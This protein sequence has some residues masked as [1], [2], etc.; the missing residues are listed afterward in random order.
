MRLLKSRTE[1]TSTFNSL[2]RNCE[3]V[4]F[5]VAWASCGFGSCD[6]LLRVHRKIRRGVVGTHFYQTDPR[7]IEKFVGRKSVKF[8]T[9]PSGVFHPKVYLFERPGSRWSC[10]IGSANFTL[11]AFG[12][13]S[14][15][16]VL[17][18]DVDGPRSAIASEV[19]HQIK[20]YWNWPTAKF[21][22]QIDL[23]RYRYWKDRFKRPIDKSQGKFGIKPAKK[24]LDEI[25]LLN[26]G[27]SELFS[28]I[29]HDPH[30]GLTKRIKVLASAR[31]LFEKYGS[32]AA[33]P[34]KDRQGIAGF[35][36]SDDIP[37]G[38]FGSM[39]GAGT[40]KKLVNENPKAFSTALDKIPLVGPVRRSDYE[41]F[42][43]H[44]MAAFPRIKRRRIRHGLATA[45]RL[46]AMKRPDYFVCFD[47]ANKVGLSKAFG[48]TI[49]HHDYNA[50]WDS[51]IERIC[52]SKWWN[53]PR[54]KAKSEQQVW[55]GRTAFLDAIFYVPVG[56]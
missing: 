21:A 37:W 31:A 48:I 18:E 19:N 9:N 14:E 53:S 52:E 54:P 27:W 29:Q 16:L 15:L 56:A 2:L 1:I 20:A 10:L 46:L 49:N 55:E 51:I 36:E 28:K 50:Y 7:F 41:A 11:G 5:A 42:L 13:N 44:Y 25:L 26:I 3:S 33:M 32:L 8:I 24:T 38:W 6:H 45:T 39:K 30:H 23:E 22:D 34:K 12:E 43:N 47:K 17:V 4:S 40:F 35:V